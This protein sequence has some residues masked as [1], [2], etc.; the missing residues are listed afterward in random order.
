MG[1]KNKQKCANKNICLLDE[2]ISY[3]STLILLYFT[4]KAKKSIAIRS[5]LKLIGWILERYLF[6]MREQCILKINELMTEGMEW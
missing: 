5:N 1:E 3:F 6:N 2:N 4:K